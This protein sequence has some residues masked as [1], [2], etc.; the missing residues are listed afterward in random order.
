MIKVSPLIAEDQRKPS[1]EGQAEI[2]CSLVRLKSLRDAVWALHMIDIAHD[3]KVWMMLDHHTN[4][5]N[6]SGADIIII[7]GKAVEA[8]VSGDTRNLEA[9]I[10]ESIEQSL[11]IGRYPPPAISQLDRVMEQFSAG[12]VV[13]SKLRMLRRVAIVQETMY[14]LWW[15]LKRKAGDVDK[16]VGNQSLLQVPTAANGAHSSNT[17]SNNELNSVFLTE[18][19]TSPRKSCLPNPNFIHCE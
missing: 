17:F 18:L 8:T 16:L 3:H 14:G 19:D 1:E 10:K 2:Q 5:L 12:S 4:K 6:I 11:L 13:L 9:H 7:M 15:V